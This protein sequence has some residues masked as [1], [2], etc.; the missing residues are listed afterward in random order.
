MTATLR[1]LSALAMLLPALGCAA[2]EGRAS[3]IDMDATPVSLAR[4][5]ALRGGADVGPALHVAFGLER[6]TTVDGVVVA[7][8][9]FDVPDIGHITAAQAQAVQAALGTLLVV[10]DGQATSVSLPLGNQSLGTFIQNSLSNQSIRNLVTIN[11]ATNSLALLRSLNANDQ[12]RG[13][14]L[15]G[16]H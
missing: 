13:L 16:G 9:R 3:A 7:S 10:R 2:Q 4:L 11:L 14:A 1:A 5:D 15:P 6:L 8:T 12:L